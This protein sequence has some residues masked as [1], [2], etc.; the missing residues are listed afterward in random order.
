[1]RPS[2]V[3]IPEVQMGKKDNY[4]PHKD[5]SF[6][7]AHGR[8]E[9]EEAK[10]SQDTANRERNVGHDKGEEHSRVPKGNRG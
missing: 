5:D 8:R 2:G 7:R 10:P 4:E 3:Q 9:G 6:N 1:M